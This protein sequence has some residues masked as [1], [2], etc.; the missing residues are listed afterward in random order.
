MDTPL[1]QTQKEI[2]RNARN[3]RKLAARIQ[4]IK[5]PLLEALDLVSPSVHQARGRGFSVNTWE[6]SE[7]GKLSAPV[8]RHDWDKLCDSGITFD[9]FPIGRGGATYLVTIDPTQ[10]GFL[11]KLTN[12]A[13]AVSA[14]MGLSP[15]P[16]TAKQD[17]TQKF[18][19]ALSKSSSTAAHR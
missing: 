15:D 4:E 5:E 11:E 6:I 12:A 18:E 13:A 10:E 16:V 17:I 19:T 2:T 9:I 7:D 3:R 1:Q 8:T 14:E